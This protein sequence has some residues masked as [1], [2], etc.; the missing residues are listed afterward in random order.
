MRSPFCYRKT[1]RS[2]ATVLYTFHLKMRAQII[3]SYFF[4]RVIVSAEVIYEV[5]YLSWI[6][7]YFRP[8]KSGKCVHVGTA[9]WQFDF[10]HLVEPCEP[11]FR[12]E[13]TCMEL[14]LNDFDNEIKKKEEKKKF[15]ALNASHIAEH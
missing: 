13:H 7:L 6:F 15:C 10:I 11:I 8:N 5:T 12:W 9:I 3:L 4:H 2:G 14:N 1:A